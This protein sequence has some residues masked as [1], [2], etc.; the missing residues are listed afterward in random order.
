MKDALA[1]AASL[2]MGSVLLDAVRRR[3]TQ[4]LKPFQLERKCA[5]SLQLAPHLL[6]IH[7]IFRA[8]NAHHSSTPEHVRH[9]RGKR[10]PSPFRERPPT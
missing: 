10:L 9:R 2:A 8:S 4:E 1:M 3:D 7:E 5:I 6:F